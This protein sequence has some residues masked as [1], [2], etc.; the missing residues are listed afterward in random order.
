ML[1]ESGE[2]TERWVQWLDIL[3]PEGLSPGLKLNYF[4]LENPIS[5]VTHHMSKST[6]LCVIT[7][8]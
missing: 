8:Q 2:H 6:G 1:R 7:R 4:R 5:F 3:I